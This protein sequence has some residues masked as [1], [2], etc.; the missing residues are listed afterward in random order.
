M[1]APKKT[2]NLT[3]DERPET[4]QERRAPAP[5][6]PRVFLFRMLAVIFFAE[7]GTL[8]FAFS[9]CTDPN[10]TGPEA[11]QTIRQR[12]PD[13]GNRSE[14][15]FAVAISTTLSLLGAAPKGE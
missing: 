4:V 15:L 12:C 8:L 10:M 9:K 11:N 1:V 5:F 6:R 14:Q 7:L 13:I 2:D 3:V